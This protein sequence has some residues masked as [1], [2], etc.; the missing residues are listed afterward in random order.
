MRRVR[1]KK[2]LGQHFLNDL[3]IITQISN[4][5]NTNKNTNILEVGPGTGNLTEFLIKKPG[6]FK[7]V[8][9]D[10][11][12]ILYLSQRF[13]EIKNK[14][15]KK[16]FLKLDL[17]NLFA[18]KFIIVGNFPYNISSQILFH[19]LKYK[20]L[21]YEIVGMFQ[22]EVAERLIAKKGSKKGILSV[23]MQAFYEIEE[24]LTIKQDAFFPS[25]KIQSSVVRFKRN[26]RQELTCDENLFIT[27]VKSGFNQKRKTLRNALKSFSL[28]NKMELDSL[29]KKRAEELSV[30]DFITIALHAKKN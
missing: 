17:Q 9:I 26:Q 10:P 14:V 30:D 20:N 4:L 29:L 15:I 3:Q 25:P 12:C 22:K 1:P 16:D 11:D 6:C 2:H 28:E 8:E 13:P 27:I 7:L 18:S 24:C 19:I 21:V 5:I 23:L